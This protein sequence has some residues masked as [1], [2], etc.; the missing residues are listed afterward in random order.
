VVSKSWLSPCHLHKAIDRWQFKIRNLRKQLNGWSINIESAHNRVKQ[1]L[2]AEF[3][4]LDNLSESETMCPISKT[5]MK[6]NLF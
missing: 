3:D 1:S 2:I 6:K 4:L 5:R